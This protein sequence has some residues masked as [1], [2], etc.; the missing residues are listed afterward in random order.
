M[1]RFDLSA[2]VDVQTRI[3][4]FWQEYPDG[5]IETVMVSPSN[6]FEH[7]TFRAEVYKRLDDAHPSATGYAYE[8]AGQSGANQTSWVE[9]SETSAIG[10]ALANLGYAT[11]QKDRPSREEMDKANRAPSQR[12]ADAPSQ[13]VRPEQTAQPQR[14]PQA[15]QRPATAVQKAELSDDDPLPWD[16]ENALMDHARRRQVRWDVVEAQA[17]KI[18]ELGGDEPLVLTVKLG[19]DLSHWIND[20]ARERGKTTPEEAAAFDR[21]L[22]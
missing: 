5:R 13:G 7:A 9:N 19:R 8:H 10:R 21:A 22:S 12:A 6:E 2:Y 11:S 1:P 4:R 17:R 20:Q 16:L 3:S 14:A 18:L 15:P